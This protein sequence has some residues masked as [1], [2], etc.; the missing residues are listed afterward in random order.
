M[1][2]EIHVY[3]FSIAANVVLSFFPFVIVMVS[4]CRYVL[5]WNAAV[6]AIFV[7]MADYFPADI[8]NFIRPRAAN[9]RPLEWLSILLLLFTANG[10]FEPMEVALNRIWGITRNRSYFR[11]QVVSIG[12]IFL[13]GT[14]AL[15][16]A[17]ATA[18][19]QSIVRN[20]GWASEEV[21]A[22]LGVFVFKLAAIPLMMVMLFIV[23]SVLPNG[24]IPVKR[25]APAAIIVGLL[26]EVLKYINLLAWPWLQV[27]FRREYGPFIYSVTIIFWSFFAAML[28]MAGA[29]WSARGR[30]AFE[31]TAEPAEA[32]PLTKE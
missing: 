4:V 11:N 2:T 28:V 7:A 18:L 21:Q 22:F 12:L 30:P 8:I 6:D 25:A 24:K 1:E 3:G 9:P 31:A 15:I 20:L 5:H 23:Y 19:N 26:L 27:K 10:I 29:E 32:V 13:C 14:L 16:S 17:I